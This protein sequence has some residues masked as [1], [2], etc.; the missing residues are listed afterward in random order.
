MQPCSQSGLT[1]AK[2]RCWLV[3]RLPSSGIPRSLSTDLPRLV[4]QRFRDS[5]S[6]LCEEL[7][8]GSGLG[9]MTVPYLGSD[10]DIIQ[11]YYWEVVWLFLCPKTHV[12]LLCLAQNNDLC[13]PLALHLVCYILNTSGLL[14]GLGLAAA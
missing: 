6:R 13:L 5:V 4:R 14:F 7:P 8:L 9:T 2:A 1:A 3:F 10:S 11:L 12:L